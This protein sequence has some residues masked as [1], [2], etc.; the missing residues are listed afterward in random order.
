LGAEHA[1]DLATTIRI[2]TINGALAGQS[3]D[4]TGSIEVGKSADFIVLDRN[5]FEVPPKKMSDT[6][7]L[8]TIVAGKEIY[9]GR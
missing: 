4:R 2:F 6:K 3:G 1:L 5:L 8:A 9:R 7:V